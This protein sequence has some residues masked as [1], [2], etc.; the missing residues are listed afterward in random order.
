MKKT[1][2]Q[3]LRGRRR[4]VVTGMGVIS[5]VGHGHQ[6]FWESLVN[7]KNGGAKVVSFDTSPFRSNVACEVKDFDFNKY[8]DENTR[9]KFSNA[10][11]ASQFAIAAANLAVKDANL[12]NW[13]DTCDRSRVGVILGTTMGEVQILHEI[14]RSLAGSGMPESTIYQHYVLHNLPQSVARHFRLQGPCSI[15]PTACASGNYAIGMGCDLIR[16]NKA[17]TMIVGGVDP[18]DSIVFA[19]F[20]RIFSVAPELCQP[21]DKNRKGLLVGEGSAILILESLEGAVNRSAKIYAEI[22]GYGL[23]CDAYHMT[24]P[25]PNVK[26]TYNAAIAAFEDAN[27]SVSRVDAI[28]AHGTGTPANDRTET[29]MIKKLF[30]DEAYKIPITANKSMIGHTMGGAA[31]MNAVTACHILSDGYIPPTI[32]Y[33]TKDS[34]CDLDYVPN[35]ARKIKANLVLSNAFA[36]GGNNTAML[37]KKYEETIL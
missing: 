15:V 22:A 26:G 23:S 4:V 25:D 5:P 13:L 6:Q 21:F 29:R 34:E 37:I 9:N 19:G 2:Y 36:F 32:N 30:G 24:N 14:V 1:K 20:S 10:G 31:A 27:L 18:I 28:I 33:Q 3:D 17:E 7:G 8:C 12:G 16:N 11:R 35:E